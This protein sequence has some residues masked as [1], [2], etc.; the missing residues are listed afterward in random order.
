MSL[1]IAF[2]ADGGAMDVSRAY[3][4]EGKWSE[5]MSM[6]RYSDVQLEEVGSS[7]FPQ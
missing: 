2:S 6:R 4:P 3:I 7:F 1:V 5:A